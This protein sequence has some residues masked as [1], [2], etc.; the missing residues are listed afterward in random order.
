MAD[1]DAEIRLKETAEQ[2]LRLRDR[3]REAVMQEAP[4]RYAWGAGTPTPSL[5]ELIVHAT[6]VDYGETTLTH[7]APG[8]IGVSHDTLLRVEQYNAAKDA[9][10]EAV[11]DLRLAFGGHQARKIAKERLRLWIGPRVSLRQL[12]RHVLWVED[13]VRAVGFT[14]ARA[15]RPLKRLTRAEAE[16]RLEAIFQQEEDLE[17]ARQVLAGVPDAIDLYEAYPPQEHLRANVQFR[18]GG[19]RMV[20]AHS[21][22]LF[23]MPPG[24]APPSH[25]QEPRPAAAR[26]PRADRRIESE[27]LIDH[28]PIYCAR[29]LPTTG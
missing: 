12:Y 9:L 19:K 11:A 25:N 4:E 6:S 5:N 8:L 17:H 15:H 28:A 20:V 1:T 22:I 16:I 2:V 23:P 18:H 26:K 13:E 7:Q 29:S 3:L 27:P 24:G 14:M 21:P 10:A